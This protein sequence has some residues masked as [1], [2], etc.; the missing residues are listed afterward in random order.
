MLTT[1]SACAATVGSCVT[2][3]SV[4]PSLQAMRW[5]SDRISS[6]VRLSRLP[7]G[8]SAKITSGLATSARA[9]PTRCC[10]PPDICDGRWL[11]CFSSPTSRSIAV[12]A[13]LRLRSPTPRYTSGMDTFSTAVIDG[14]RL[15]CWKMKP[16]CCSRKFT[17]CDSLI[18]SKCCPAITMLPRVGFS[19][20]A[21]MLS[22]VDLPL[23]DRPMMHTNSPG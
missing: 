13:A 18:F 23:P 16:M 22:S 1:R 15:N 4:C 2:I 19:S 3:T 12:A 6:L 21:I 17:S 8:S 20:P 5:M 7:V 11:M 14:N 10:C 9:M